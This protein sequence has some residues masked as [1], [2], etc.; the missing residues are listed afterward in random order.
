MLEQ[1]I[2]SASSCNQHGW[3]IRTEPT[4]QTSQ[5]DKSLTFFFCL[6]NLGTWKKK[7]KEWKNGKKEKKKLDA[8]TTAPTGV[9][10]R[11]SFKT[12][13]HT[14]T[15]L[16]IYVKLCSKIL[17]RPDIPPT[18]H[19]NLYRPCLIMTLIPRTGGGVD[20]YCSPFL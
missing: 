6:S 2:I 16:I 17:R 7:K 19:K 11:F 1:S 10:T 14:V 13:T 5:S 20:F 18:I 3:R 8:V 4:G 9:P 12:W 15:S